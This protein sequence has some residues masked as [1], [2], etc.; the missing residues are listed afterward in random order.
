MV[1]A[2]VVLSDYGTLMVEILKDNARPLHCACAMCS[3]MI[4]SFE[5]HQQCSRRLVSSIPS[6]PK[7][8]AKARS[9]WFSERLR[10]S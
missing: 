3:A 7:W 4:C 5:P 10:T 8:R 2:G 9:V 1:Q 6:S